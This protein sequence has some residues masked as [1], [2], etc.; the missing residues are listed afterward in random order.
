MSYGDTLWKLLSSVI[1]I[2]SEI[3]LLW[4]CLGLVHYLI[5]LTSVIILNLVLR[6]GIHGPLFRL[7]VLNFAL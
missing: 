6:D 7:E 1:T 3:V 2:C 5:L 4:S